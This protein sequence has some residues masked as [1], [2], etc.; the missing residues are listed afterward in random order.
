MVTTN[1]YRCRAT[2]AELREGKPRPQLWLFMNQQEL[3]PKSFLFDPITYDHQGNAGPLLRLPEKKRAYNGDAAASADQQ[4]IKQ[5]HGG[6][7]T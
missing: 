2:A 7:L 4:V 6:A 5:P 1:A 3:T